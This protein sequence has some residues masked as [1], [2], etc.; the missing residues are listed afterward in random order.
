MASKAKISVKIEE[1][2]RISIHRQ[3]DL[4]LQDENQVEYD[5]PSDLT[6]Q[7]RAYIHEYVRNKQLKSK[8]HGK[9][10]NRYLTICKTGLPD[11][12]HDDA[13]LNV[14]PESG[15]MLK[16]IE[17]CSNL[18]CKPSKRLG[19]GTP[20]LS[21]SINVTSTA[22]SIPPLPTGCA[23]IHAARNRLPIAQFHEVI[24]RSMQQT[25]VI[26]ISGNTGSGKTTQVP[27]YILE[28]AA[29]TN[30]P[31]RIICTQ[32]RRISAVTV[33]ERVCYERNEPLGDTVGYQIRLESRVKP[34]TNA[35]FCTNGVLL[36]CLIGKVCTNFLK[37]ITHIII[38]EVH[39]R[40]QYSDFLLIALRDNLSKNPLLKI[41]LM[42]ATIESD[43]F[44]KYFNNAPVI[45]IPGRLFP[46]E[47]VFLEDIL[48]NIETYNHNVRDIRTSIIENTDGQFG[49]RCKPVTV[50]MDDE[51]ILLMNDILEVCWMDDNPN[52]FRNFFVLI[53]EENIPIDFQHT[54]TQMTALMIAAAK[55]YYEIV[56][57]LL[58]MGADPNIKVKH[59]FNAFDWTCIMNRS[60]KCSELLKQA[61]T[62][63]DLPSLRIVTP[64]PNYAKQLLDAYHTSVG[65][66]RV[67]HGLIF[68]IIMHICQQKTAGGIL[69][70]L[71]G[72]DDIQE[73]YGLINSKMSNLHYVRVLML[74]SKMQTTDQHSVFKPVPSGVRKI[75]LS[76]NIAETSITMDDVVYVIDSGKVKQKYYDSLTSASSLAATWI[77]QA[78]AT[79]RAGRAGRTSPGTCFR[80]YSR[81]RH[82]S[83]DQ[84]TLPEILRVSLTEICLQTALMIKDAS[85]QEFL[86]KAITPPAATSIKQSIK[87]LQKVG[88]L[89]DDENVTDLGYTLAELPVDARLGKMLLYGILMKCYEPVLLIVC[90]LSVNDLFV[91]PPFS[92]DKERAKKMRYDLSD[93]SYSDCY[94]LIRA[95]QR[96]QATRS[97]LKRKEL[98]NR[99]FLNH[100]KLTMVHD[101]RN[102]LHAHLCTIGVIKSYGPGNVHDLNEH[103]SNWSLMK[104]ILLMGLYPNVCY[105]EKYSKTLK[106]RFEKKI[107]IH[108]SSVVGAKMSNKSKEE[109]NPLSLPSEWITFEEK[110]KTGRASMIRCNTVVSPISIAIFAGPFLLDETECIVRQEDDEVQE[111]RCRIMI[112]D[113]INLMAQ[114]NVAKSVLHARQ[115]LNELFLKFVKNPKAH[116][117]DPAELKML[118]Y[119][120]RILAAEDE[121]IQVTSQLPD[122]A[123]PANKQRGESSCGYQR[124][125]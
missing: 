18:V 93:S 90:I 15:V 96:W 84:Y 82:S 29:Q 9:G 68:D 72:Y 103:A 108:P 50:N 2:I 117:S 94:S 81:T 25:Q 45:E 113:W 46:V 97:V 64:A 52:D 83:M 105:L 14:S 101:L 59:N 17:K 60:G 16:K 19:K 71:P 47:V 11:I 36:R 10:A 89:D 122:F 91:I 12:I 13:V 6:N 44:S 73:Q 3:I 124:R 85:I 35:L 56:Q 27:Q 104:G 115:A 86:N 78:C 111:R 22:P 92:G 75:I 39:E 107:F 121:L 7:H 80:L 62:K 95:Y 41:I 42:S 98:C 51:I 28:E 125:R 33:A 49:E 67:D 79:Q 88:A 31:C 70:F 123:K 30:Q 87:Y 8:S 26:I 110:C 100:G 66:N 23:E 74:H 34:T 77:S 116:Q 53:E 38:D 102:K 24:L 54:E 55:D 63:V 120:S 109:T 69:V 20:T 21:H 118:D 119:L 4:F 43:T 76:T 65:D 57:K 114:E 32:P 1:D 58:D 99:L 112:D 61:M 40:D 5:F 106:T 48:L 37:N